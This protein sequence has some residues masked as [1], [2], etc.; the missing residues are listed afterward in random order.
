[1]PSFPLQSAAAARILERLVRRRIRNE[2]SHRTAVSRENELHTVAEE[3]FPKFRAVV[4]AAFARGR[5]AVDHAAL[6]KAT[7]IHDAQVAISPAAFATQR[8]LQ[9]ELPKLLLNLV[10]AGGNAGLKR[11]GSVRGLRAAA[12]DDL[13][14]MRFDVTNPDVLEWIK[15]H[16]AELIDGI[17]ETTRQNITDAIVAAFESGTLREAYDDILELVGDE[18][19]AE[20]ITRTECMMAAN[21]GQRESWSQ[22]E[23]AGL[24][25]GDE[26]R[27]WIATDDACPKCEELDGQEA[28]LDGVYLGDGENGPPLHPNSIVAGVLVEG[29]TIAATRMLYAGQVREIVMI[30]GRTLTITPHHSVATLRGFIPAHD[31]E[32]GEY[33]FSYNERIERS[34]PSAESFYPAVSVFF[35]P[36][37]NQDGPTTIEQV[38]HSLKLT[39]KLVVAERFGDEFHGDA[40]YGNGDIDIVYADVELGNRVEATVED[41]REGLVLESSDLLVS[42]L[43]NALL[44]QLAARLTKP[45]SVIGLRPVTQPTKTSRIGYTAYLDAVLFEMARHFN[46]RDASFC[47][48]LVERLAGFIT[49]DEVI[50]VRNRDYFEHVYDL[51]TISGVIVAN[52]F[53]ISNCRCTEGIV[54]G[55]PED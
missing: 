45:A 34:D 12:D 40:A 21:E 8:Y 15:E 48:E 29:N 49:Q 37:E 51:N 3:F 33:L 47:R 46:A 17:T 7:T 30:S 54:A 11:L 43:R 20:L 5:F 52:G 14:S 32:K 13:Y 23:E 53:I 26:K 22:A 18:S 55:P 9:R 39:G 27:V 2:V 44:V 10:K 16:T 6:R 19:R 41:Q 50:E 25:T 28:D 36:Q 35:S 4:R 24:L 42:G 38:F 31:V 1:V